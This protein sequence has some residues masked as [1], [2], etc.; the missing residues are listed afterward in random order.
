MSKRIG[1]QMRRAADLV[2][3]NPGCNK[4]FVA[5][6]LHRACAS[7]RNNKLGYDPINRAIEAGLIRA[8][9]GKGNS[10]ALFPR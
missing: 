5:S 7:G 10:F 9:A 3:Q 2:T 1:Y 4:F 6:R 8:T